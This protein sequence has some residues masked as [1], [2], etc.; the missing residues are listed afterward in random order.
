MT[1]ARYARSA[2]ALH[3]AIAILLLF[4]LGL[5]WHMTSMGRGAA[6]FAAFQFHKSIGILVLALTLLRI[7][8]R[9]VAPRPRPVRTGLFTGLLAKL[10]HFGLYAFMLGAPLTGWAVVSTAKIA[11]PTRL[12]WSVPWPHLPIGR[13]WNAL[14]AS[15]HEMLAWI[16]VGLFLLHLA[17]AIRHHL[18]GAHENVIG[19]MIPAVSRGAAAGRAIPVALGLAG[20]LALCFLAPWLLYVAGPVSSAGTMPVASAAKAMAVPSAVPASPAAENAVEEEAAPD[21]PAVPVR[22]TVLDGG[23]LG[24]TA[25]MNGSP[26]NGH[27]AKWSADILF[28]PEAL[29]DS[30]ITVRVP[31]LTADTGDADRDAMLKGPSFFGAAGEAANFSS[32][33]IS[34]VRDDRYRA[35]GTMR[36]NGMSHP[37]TL[38]FTLRIVGDRA[39]VAGAARLD[40]TSFAIGSGEWASTDQIAAN[41]E[42][43]FDFSARRVK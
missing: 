10:V 32:T 30:R 17:G 35:A 2:I 3:W 23:T 4:Q 26:I 11:V 20:F 5:G 43:N 40:R 25:A 31:L 19:R 28:D 7:A 37:V 27:F 22:W 34:H 9:I 41:V 15:G 42:L 33:S 8:V 6:M 1:A 36:M 24:F 14:A 16:G 38:N 12:F 29:A 39:K 13:A 21:E 18:G